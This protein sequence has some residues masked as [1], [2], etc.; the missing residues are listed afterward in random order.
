[1]SGSNSLNFYRTSNPFASFTYWIYEASD[2]MKHQ[3]LSSSYHLHSSQICLL[4][5]LRSF[6]VWLYT[7][8]QPM[9]LKKK[10]DDSLLCICS[11][12]GL[13]DAKLSL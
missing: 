5:S 2:H 1:M 3:I 4:E 7:V 13:T 9:L 12:A 10:N 6:K 8:L 11:S